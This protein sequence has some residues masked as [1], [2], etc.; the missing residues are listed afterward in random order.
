M[1]QIKLLLVFVIALSTLVFAGCGPPPVLTTSITPDNSGTVS[2]NGGTYKSG[3]KITLVATP[4]KYYNFTGW[5]G[6]VSG[7]TNPM[8]IKMDSN[9]NIVASFTKILY[10][11]QFNLSGSGS[12]TFNMKSGNY[13]AG[14]QLTISATPAI[15]SRFDHWEGSA[16]GN[17]NQLSILMDADKTITANFIKQ[18]KLT[19]AVDPSAGKVNSNGG[20]Y[21]AGTSVNLTATPAF[22]YAFQNWV[23]ADNNNINPTNVTINADKSVSASFVQLKGK[24]PVQNSGNTY[25]TA[26]ISINLNKYEWVEGTINLPDTGLPAHAAYIQGPDSKQIKDFKTV[27]TDSFQIMASVSG[28]YTINIEAN[29]MSSWGTNYNVTYTVY[30]Q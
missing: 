3:T 24:T 16:T 6:E 1:K 21:D 13:E 20:L 19:V 12:G 23:G 22:P 2:P 25:R 27:G 29:F 8:T 28:T 18:Y 26:T 15:G 30:V 7:T 9:K 14:N 10:N 5:A 4:A 17:A 11:L